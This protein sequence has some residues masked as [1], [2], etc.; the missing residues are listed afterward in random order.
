MDNEATL[1]RL[2]TLPILSALSEDVL[3][4]LAFI[5]HEKAF[6]ADQAI[7]E[8]GEEGDSL[9]FILE[10]SVVIQKLIEGDEIRYKDLA[11][12]E[13]GDIIGEMALFDR[14]PRSAT[15]RAREP[16]KVLLIYRKDFEEFLRADSGSASAILGGLLSLQN[17]RLREA[18][19]QN[20]TIYELVNIIAAVHDL[21]ELAHLVMDRLIASLRQVDAA[22]FCHWNEYLDE[23]EVLYTRGVNVDD[24]AIFS[25]SRSGP[26]ARILCEHTEPFLLANL[27][28]EHPLRRVFHLEERDSILVTALRQ[29]D[30]LLGYL[31]LVG[32]GIPFSSFHRLL[33]AAVAAPTSTA[34]VNARYAQDAQARDRLETAKMHGSHVSGSRRRQ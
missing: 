16:V 1:A 12:S 6:E 20:V 2:K 3:H 33:V 4:K 15:V 29:E 7:V 19:Q 10:G 30:D 24:Q 26:M 34:I 25:I 8:E 27:D 21:K 13:A 22:V 18:A 28:E 23:C 32:R 31:L 17:S 5:G 14:K 9:F 11:I